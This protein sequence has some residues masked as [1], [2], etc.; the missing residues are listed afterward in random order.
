MTNYLKWCFP[1]SSNGEQ[2]AEN[3]F[4]KVQAHNRKALLLWGLLCCFA[5]LPALRSWVLGYPRNS[6]AVTKFVI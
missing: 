2:M 5:V 6:Y 3:F 4:F 1:L